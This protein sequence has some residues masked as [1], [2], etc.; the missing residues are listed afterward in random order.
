MKFNKIFISLL[1]CLTANS[2]LKS[3]YYHSSVTEMWLN[4]C[5]ILVGALD[6]FYTINNDYPET[7]AELVPYYVSE[8]PVAPADRSMLKYR[9]YQGSYQLSFEHNQ[10]DYKECR[11]TPAIGWRCFAYE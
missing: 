4:R 3:P 1:F 9:K 10:P 5:D 6:Y 11:Y 7:L 8:F 2:C